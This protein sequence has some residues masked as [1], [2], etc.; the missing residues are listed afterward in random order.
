MLS[1]LLR[2]LVVIPHSVDAPVTALGAARALAIARQASLDTPYA[3]QPFTHVVRRD[4]ARTLHVVTTTTIGQQFEVTIDDAT[5]NVV[6]AQTIG[7]R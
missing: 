2:V 6:S 7:T 4:G 5:G 3:H 1:R